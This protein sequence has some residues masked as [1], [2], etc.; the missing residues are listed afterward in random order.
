VKGSAIP[1]TAGEMA[2][3]EDNRMMVISDYHA[4]FCACFGR[5]DASLKN[6]HALRKRKGWRTGRTGCFEPGQVPVN[7]GKPCAPGKGGRHPNAQR[8]QF[9]KGGRTG[10]AAMLYKP[11]GTERLTKDGYL[12]RKMHDGLPMQSRWQLVQRVEWEAVNGPIPAGHALKCLD[13]DRLNTDPANW[14]PVPRGVLALLNE[15]RHRKR[16]AYDAAAPEL[17]PTVMLVAKLHHGVLHARK[18]ATA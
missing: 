5:T 1:Y 11:I 17:K 18:R 9:A 15:G 4:A 8:T 6:L 16:L 3:L 7:K 12:Q 14:E 2:W 13:G 10:K